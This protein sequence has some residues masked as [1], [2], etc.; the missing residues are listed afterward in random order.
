MQHLVIL[1]LLAYVIILY[2]WRNPLK[3]TSSFMWRRFLSWFPLGMTYSFMYMSRYNLDQLATADIL[4]KAQK[5][6]ISGSGFFIYAA[7]LFISGPLIDRIGGKKGMIMAALGAAIANVA[8]GWALYLH[9]H[10][11]APIE[12]L[13]LQLTVLYSVNMFFQSF[14]AIS[15][16]KVKSFWFHVRERGTFGAIFGTLISLGIYFAFDWTAAIMRA[17]DLK[18]SGESYPFRD[19]IQSAFALQNA[20]QSAYW[21]VFFIPAG[22]LLI[23]ALIDLLLIKDSPD[24]A[25]FG[26]F[27][28]YDASHGHAA[29]IDSW[30]T[31]IKSVFTN[32]VLLMIGVIEF[33]SGV[34]RDGTV[35]W[36]LIYGK[37]TGLGV[38]VITSNWGWFLAITGIIGAFVAGWASDRFF[39]SRRAPVA[40]I[41]Q[42]VMFVAS[43]C[44]IL[45]IATNANVVGVSALILVTA[46]IAVHSIMS[47]TATAD[48]GG[49]K[50]AAT[51]TGVADGF[52]KLGSSF[53]EFVLGMVLTRETWYIWPSFLLPFTVLGLF[54]A[55]KLWRELPEA[56]K[57]YLAEVE[58]LK[59]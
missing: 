12:H 52:S 18:Y 2:F 17:V 34:L 20:T 28:T 13:V 4:T 50:G 29:T 21:L 54:F 8:M 16:I 35:K 46:V 43:L 22:L 57:R 26:K 37:E 25:G 7:S 33:T 31:T 53:Q 39:Q 24:Q 58:K 47:G 40:G 14:G 3:H 10:G 36:Y 41:A 48:F 1:G 19:F 15:T 9:M 30:W 45:T 5:A 42:M 44:M 6:A 49:R 56:T 55:I 59:V 38:P 23:W 27:E 32:R 11:D 51:A